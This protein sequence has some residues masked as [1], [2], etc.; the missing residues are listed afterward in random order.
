MKAIQGNV[1]NSIEL[2]RGMTIQPITVMSLSGRQETI[3]YADYSKPT[4]FYIFSPTCHWCERNIQNINALVSLKGESF[5]F[6]GLSLADDGLTEYVESHRFSFPIYKSLTPDTI[7]MLG[8]A[9][10]PQTIIISPEGRVLENWVGAFGERLE[11]QVEEY[12]KVRLPGLT[13]EKN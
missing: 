13:A 10:T 1:Q 5:R 4:V 8:L 2:S 7:R 9:G 11:P 3:T 6:I 12:F